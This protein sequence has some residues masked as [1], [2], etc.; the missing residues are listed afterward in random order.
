LET[1]MNPISL[2]S[3][4]VIAY[5]VAA[6]FAVFAALHIV[7]PSSMTQESVVGA[8][9]LV[10]AVATAI[11]RFGR[12][13]QPGVDAKTWWQSKTI[14]LQLIAAAAGV[15]AIF[16]VVLPVDQGQLAG[17]ILLIISLVNALLHRGVTQPIASA[18]AA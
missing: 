12:P 2:P 9:M 18:P 7:L 15:L 5:L 17:A 14:W 6:L 4:P 10:L 16:H 3:R 11:V 8:V 13:G 1:I